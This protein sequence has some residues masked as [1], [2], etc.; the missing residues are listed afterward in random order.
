[1]SDSDRAYVYVAVYL[2]LLTRSNL[3]PALASWLC[4]FIALP[5]TIKI[6]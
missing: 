4:Q 2:Q 3:V 1:M 5:I 6:A